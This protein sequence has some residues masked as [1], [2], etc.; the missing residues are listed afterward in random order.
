MDVYGVKNNDHAT[1]LVE[2]EMIYACC[3]CIE[4]TTLFDI[5]NTLKNNEY[6]ENSFIHGA[7][8]CIEYHT[9]IFNN[10]NE[11]Y[12]PE[13]VKNSFNEIEKIKEYLLKVVE[14]N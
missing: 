5:H 12:K 2:K 14:E 3:D 7:L 8:E 13:N 11:K 1:E 4:Y 9:I 10:L 6:I